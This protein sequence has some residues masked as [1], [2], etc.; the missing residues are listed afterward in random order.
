M[1]SVPRLVH[2]LASSNSRIS[3]SGVSDVEECARMI[4]IA[5]CIA[6]CSA[7]PYSARSWLP[8]DQFPLSRL[9]G[10]SSMG[11]PSRPRAAVSTSAA[12]AAAR[13]WSPRASASRMIFTSGA[14]TKRST[15]G[16]TWAAALL[17]FFPR[18][19]GGVGAASSGCD[20]GCEASGATG[21]STSPSS[22]ESASTLSIDSGGRFHPLLRTRRPLGPDAL[23]SPSAMAKA[24]LRSDF[25]TNVSQI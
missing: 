21:A 4:S 24:P 23:T 13:G 16:A 12:A 1:A 18:D 10:P 8:L 17:R 22:S 11:S 2:R 6:A 7:S 19:T 20:C 5:A 14:S 15:L 3:S 9:F 25:L